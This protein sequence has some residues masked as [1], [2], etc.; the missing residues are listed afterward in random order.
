MYIYKITLD[1]NKIDCTCFFCSMFV[2]TLF[3]HA[4]L[5][6]LRRGICCDSQRNNK[7]RAMCISCS[8]FGSSCCRDGNEALAAQKPLRCSFSATNTSVKTPQ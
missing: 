8:M 1:F 2:Q 3:Y 6:I 5:N 4:E 7:Q